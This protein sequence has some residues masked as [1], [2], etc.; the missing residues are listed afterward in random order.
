M[1]P[2]VVSENDN[3]VATYSL[4]CIKELDGEVGGAR[5]RSRLTSWPTA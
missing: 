5:I 2:P 4:D 3:G 1:V